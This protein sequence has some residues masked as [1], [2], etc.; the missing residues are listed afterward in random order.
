MMLEFCVTSPKVILTEIFF[1]NC[2]I[3]ILSDYKC[4]EKFYFDKRNGKTREKHK[5]Y[6]FFFFYDTVV[7]FLKLM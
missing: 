1:F 4:R 5:L 7:S 6:I 2:I 3:N